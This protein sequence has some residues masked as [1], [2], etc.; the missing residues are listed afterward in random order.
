M[1]TEDF[2]TYTEVDP[3]GRVAVTASKLDVNGMLRNEDAYVYANKDADFFGATFDHDLTV[4]RASA[5]QS[6]LVGVWCLSNTVDDLYALYIGTEQALTVSFF[7]KSIFLRECEQNDTDSYVGTVNGGIYYLTIER[8]GETVLDVRIYSDSGRTTLTDTIS[9]AVPYGRRYQYIF[10][11]NS[12]NDGRTEVGSLDVENLNIYQIAPLSSYKDIFEPDLFNA[13]TFA[14]GTWRGGT[15]LVPT[16][17]GLE[18]TAPDNRL[19]V[20]APDN[21]L[22]LTTTNR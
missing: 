16:V 7:N 17:P 18:V 1:A 8:T 11:T 15:S 22:H 19:H 12:W 5:D 14:S 13:W 10:G 21:R 4:T 6:F 3:N 20:T 2:T 9:V